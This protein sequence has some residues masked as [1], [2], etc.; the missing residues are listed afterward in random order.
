MDNIESFQIV[1]ARKPLQGTVADNVTAWG[2]GGINVDGC[3]VGI[4]KDVPGSANGHVSGYSGG[5]AGRDASTSGFNPNIGR[6]P[7]NVILDESAGEAL[8]EQSGWS[9]SSAT[10]RNRIKKDEFFKGKKRMPAAEHS[11]S[12]GASRFFYTAKASKSE[13]EAGLEGMEAKRS[14]MDNQTKAELKR[15]NVDYK[16]AAGKLQMGAQQPRANHH[17]TVKPIALMRYLVR[18]VTPKGGTVLDPFMGSGSTGCA[19]MCEGVNFVGIELSEE[20]LE[21]A[22]RR[23]EY[24]QSQNPMGL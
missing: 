10:P 16:V 12:G 15:G 9:R 19:A 5:W 3:R 24:W 11:D 20:Y 4:T 1:M 14:I 2:V 13:R 22:R 21:I 8:D 18:L 6:W 17:P 23:I 7:A